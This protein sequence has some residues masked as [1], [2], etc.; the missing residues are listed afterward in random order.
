MDEGVTVAL[1]GKMRLRKTIKMHMRML[2]MCFLLK[3]NP[4]LLSKGVAAKEY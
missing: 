3:E 2:K 1:G 4:R